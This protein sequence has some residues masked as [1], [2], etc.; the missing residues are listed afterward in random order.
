MYLGASSCKAENIIT[1]VN[2]SDLGDDHV[3]RRRV[4]LFESDYLECRG[5]M[6]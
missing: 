4:D 6:L 3:Q 1:I 5:R 2:T